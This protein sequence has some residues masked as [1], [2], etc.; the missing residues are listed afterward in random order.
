MKEKL[1]ALIPFE[2]GPG[3]VVRVTLNV[4]FVTGVAVGL[5]L[6]WLW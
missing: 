5:I 6:S 2:F 4:V 1:F 3:Y